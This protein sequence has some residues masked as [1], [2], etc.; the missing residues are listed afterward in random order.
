MNII[1]PS[2][3]EHVALVGEGHFAIVQKFRRADG[4]LVAIKSLRKEHRD[5]PEYQHR[6]KREIELT[7]ALQDVDGIVPILATSADLD[8]PDVRYVMPLA[9]CNLQEFIKTNNSSLTLDDRL[10]IFDSV[11]DAVAG[12]HARAIL[13]RDLSPRNVLVMRPN[14][15]CSCVV[16]DFG[17]GKDLSADS[18]R[19]RG[20]AH[21]YGHAYYV[22]PEQR[23]SLKD[24][25]VLSDVY[26]LGRLLNFVMTGKDPD[27][28]HPC[29]M[30]AVIR[31]ATEPDP[32]DRYPTVEHMR[33]HYERLKKLELAPDDAPVHTLTQ[34]LRGLPEPPPFDEVHRRLVSPEFEDHV[35]YGYIDPALDFLDRG[36][37]L[38]D[39][40]DAVGSDIAAFADRFCSAIRECLG[41]VGWPFR[42]MD[43]FGGFL[44]RLYYAADDADARA[45]CL[46]TLWD[47]AY[48]ADQWAVQR[49]LIG[50]FKSGDL[51]EDEVMAVAEHILDS[52]TV[53]EDDRLADAAVP[54]PI[55]NAIAQLASVGLADGDDDE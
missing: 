26:S 8:D 25:T 2:Q 24:A 43:G 35:F 39:Y 1:D 45:E 28:H 12:A 33:E 41:T 17:L 50:L 49:L 32:D 47:I 5:D 9:T 16:S 29:S 30:S 14:D 19:T 48:G 46:R 4:S 21:D 7:D 13:H 44:R 38:E 34:Y 15:P 51:G 54:L 20:S 10:A 18:G 11:L 27:H 36:S 40:C 55:R 31:R 53:V 6:L 23:A 52:D 3:Y 22:A 42:E 37:R